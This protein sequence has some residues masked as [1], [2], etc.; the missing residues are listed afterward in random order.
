MNIELINVS[1]TEEEL[2][3]IASISHGKDKSSNYVGL[4][5]HCFREKHYSIFRHAYL[6][7]KVNNCPL[8]ILRQWNRHEVGNVYHLQKKGEFGYIE[9]SFRYTKNPTLSKPKRLIDA[10]G[11]EKVDDINSMI[12]TLYEG[13]INDGVLPEVARMVLPMTLET[14]F[15]WTVSV[16][17]LLTSFFPQRLDNKAQL[18]IR[19]IAK[20][21]LDIF[22]HEYPILGEI[23]SYE[24]S[25]NKK[26]YNILKEENNE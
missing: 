8:F 11:E 19:E 22:S 7:F 1:M 23:I 24:L 17:S 6:T 26:R 14:A 15:I 9:Q 2:A 10:L 20:E 13:M 4:L 5:K 18:E 16:E 12:L 25:K 21:I 3:H